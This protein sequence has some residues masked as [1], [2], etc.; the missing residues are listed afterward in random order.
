[1]WV[2]GNSFKSSLVAVVVPKAD[3]LKEWAKG[4]GKSGAR[5][6][7]VGRVRAPLGLCAQRSAMAGGVV[8]CGVVW[9]GAAR[10]P[11]PPSV[12]A[13][14]TANARDCTRR[15]R[16]RDARRAGD[17]AQLV[18]DPAAEAWM[19]EQLTAVGKENKVRVR[20]RARPSRRPCGCWQ[21]MAGAVKCASPAC[22]GERTRHPRARVQCATSRT[23]SHPRT[24]DQQTG[25]GL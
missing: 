23:R 7:L 5:A 24:T 10:S 20:A 17:V 15:P 19:L 8:W 9:C 4:A 1:V 14:C 6:F 21:R 25:Q 2:Y 12:T 18:K 22:S 16:T 13:A 3:A 11:P